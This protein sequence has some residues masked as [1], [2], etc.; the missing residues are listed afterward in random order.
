[1]GRRER[2]RHQPLP[3]VSSVVDVELCSRPSFSF[4]FNRTRS[5]CFLLKNSCCFQTF[6]SARNN[7]RSEK[8]KCIL[9]ELLKTQVRGKKDGHR[10]HVIVVNSGRQFLHAT[11]HR[12]QRLDHQSPSMLGH[13]FFFL[14]WPVEKYNGQPSNKNQGLQSVAPPYLKFGGHQVNKKEI[15]SLV[16]LDVNS[17]E[18]SCVVAV[19]VVSDMLPL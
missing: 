7:K 8:S 19:R 1:M 4:R 2:P 3:S 14:F 11:R 15:T 12:R 16:G 5:T 6:V 9:L 13:S 10:Q 17:T 18:S